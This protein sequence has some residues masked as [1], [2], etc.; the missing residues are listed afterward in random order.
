M[1]AIFLDTVVNGDHI[2]MTVA[3]AIVLL[4]DIMPSIVWQMMLPPQCYVVC[5]ADGKTLWQVLWPHMLNKWQVL[6]PMWQEKNAGH[7]N[8]H[9]PKVLEAIKNNLFLRSEDAML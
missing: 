4:G 6:L 1:C 7:T 5:V 2:A 3:M 8:T 9:T